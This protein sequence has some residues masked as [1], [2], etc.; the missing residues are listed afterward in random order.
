MTEQR[1]IAEWRNIRIFANLPS[2]PLMP[3]YT[4]YSDMLAKD[5]SPSKEIL[6]E[7]DREYF[8][9]DDKLAHMAE[10]SLP[11]AVAS[12]LYNQREQYGV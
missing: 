6:I 12:I 1:L 11:M 9:D 2:S 8:Y 4:T 3:V 7:W 10:E 5:K